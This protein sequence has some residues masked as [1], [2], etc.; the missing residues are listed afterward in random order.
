MLNMPSLQGVLNNFFERNT[1][2]IANEDVALAENE[3]EH[4][5]VYIKHDAFFLASKH[6]TDIKTWQS[7]KNQPRILASKHENRFQHE[8]IPKREVHVSLQ[9]HESHVQHVIVLERDFC[10][11]LQNL[12]VRFQPQVA[13]FS[14]ELTIPH[15]MGSR[16]VL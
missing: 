1:S 7:L 12:E 4:N 6:D 9:K 11:S 16:L 10:I 5:Y 15:S 8:A 3:T 13:K 14:P 2:L